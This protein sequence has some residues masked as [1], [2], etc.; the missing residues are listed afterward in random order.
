MYVYIIASEIKNWH[1]VGIT[2][3]IEN[4]V[5]RHNLGKERSTKP[6]RPYKLIFAQETISY[7]GARK[8]EKFLKIRFN[9]EALFD[10]V[11]PGW[12]NW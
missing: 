5:T 12:R 2:K 10:I 11:L 4:R 3:D 1:Y 6:Y 7:K 8:I 9:K